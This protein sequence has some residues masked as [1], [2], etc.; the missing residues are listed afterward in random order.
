[1]TAAVC[2]ED[3]F[4]T[5][6]S[7]KGVSQTAK[8]L[9]VGERKVHERRRKI[10]AKRGIIIR[11]PSNRSPTIALEEHPARRHETIK[12][13]VVLIASDAHYWPGIVSTAHRAFV[14]FCKDIK[15]EIIIKNGDELDFPGI[16][17]HPSIGWE[18]RP[19]V[20]DE[21]EA[22]KERLSEVEDASKNSRLYWTLGNH[23]SRFE[24]RLATVAS[25]YAKVHGVHLKDHFPRWRPCWSVWIN[26]DTVVKHRFK[27]GT[28][29]T[30]SNTMWSGK[31]MV[32][33]H[34]H[35][36]KVTPLSD[37]NGTRWGVDSGTL[38]DPYGP[39]FVNYTE[40][41]SLNWRSGFVVLTFKDGELLWPEVVHVRKEGQVE[42]RGTVIEV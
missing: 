24:T 14:K 39:Q 21:I 4:I 33:G 17:R 12:N 30:H 37:Y 36:L 6:V 25:E 13:G 16:S 2:T 9:G 32:T 22:A 11:S 29:A 35:S 3:E 38:A 8:F 26:N 5:L 19:K 40:D 41:N 42:F 31:T 34:L 27:G 10:E 1:M 7:T 15:P 18:E 28:H 23:D 20:V